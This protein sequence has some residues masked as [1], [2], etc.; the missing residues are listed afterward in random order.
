MQVGAVVEAAVAEQV[1]AEQV[2][3][4]PVRL[5]APLQTAR[6]I[7]AVGAVEEGTAAACPVLAVLVL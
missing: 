4:V 7:L 6:Q 3:A 1:L 5:A 2:G